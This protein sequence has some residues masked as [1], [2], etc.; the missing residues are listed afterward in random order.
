MVKGAQG[1]RQAVQ[2][3]VIFGLNERNKIIVLLTH[4]QTV[5]HK[6]ESE[7]T[8]DFRNFFECF[9]IHDPKCGQLFIGSCKLILKKL[10]FVRSFQ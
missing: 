10:H 2:Q 1:V 9:G 7:K 5:N 8:V 4:D 6:R 3:P